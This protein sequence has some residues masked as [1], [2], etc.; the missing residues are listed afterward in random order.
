M[1]KYNEIVLSYYHGDFDM[2]KLFKCMGKDLVLKILKENE[3]PVRVSPTII[4]C[5]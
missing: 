1:N 5:L 4:S 2:S 3:E